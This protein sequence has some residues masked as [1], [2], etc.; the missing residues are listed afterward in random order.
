MLTLFFQYEVDSS[1][2][3]TRI[4]ISQS[5][6]AFLPKMNA[7]SSWTNA[8]MYETQF[9][10][11]NSMASRESSAILAA[12]TTAVESAVSGVSSSNN[13]DGV[14][15][16][17]Y[18]LAAQDESQV[19]R[20][21]PAVIAAL[22]EAI[23]S[24]MFTGGDPKNSLVTHSE[25]QQRLRRALRV[26]AGLI[27]SGLN[28]VMISV[29]DMLSLIVSV[30]LVQ[31]DKRT[32]NANGKQNLTVPALAI[33]EIVHTRTYAAEVLSALVDNAS[34]LWPEIHSQ[35][36]EVILEQAANVIHFHEPES[37]ATENPSSQNN[38]EPSLRVSI[39]SYESFYGVLVGLERL[40]LLSQEHESVV[41]DLFRPIYDAIN[42]GSFDTS[43][44]DS[45]HKETSD[46]DSVEKA[47]LVICDWDP[48]WGSHCVSALKKLLRI[49]EVDEVEL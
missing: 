39:S 23:Y 12:L 21:M 7:Q 37:D 30:I 3:D 34:E 40:S 27:T 25:Q 32:P 47:S 13:V 42:Q 41:D 33:A 38:V 4:S 19:E 16:L 11:E 24:C 14:S 6:V 28:S 29:G 49:E 10:G 5:G 20:I 44:E 9:G 36:A 8:I 22:K 46:P 2:E 35:V 31:N 26:A 17:L 15:S 1:L 18:E 48:A 45:L 43:A